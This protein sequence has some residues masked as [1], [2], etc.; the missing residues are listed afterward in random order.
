MLCEG[1][2]RQRGE[3]TLALL[4]YSKDNTLCLKQV[5]EC[6]LDKKR[7]RLEAHFNGNRRNSSNQRRK[8]SGPRK[9]SGNRRTG[10]GQRGTR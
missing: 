2:R 6:L 5:K 3:R 9:T 4:E 10:F 1:M 8:T 7:Y